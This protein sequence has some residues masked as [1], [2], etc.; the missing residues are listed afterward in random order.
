MSVGT[1]LIN[2]S[3]LDG[4]KLGHDV[5]DMRTLS[6]RVQ[7]I[8]MILGVSQDA[9]GAPRKPVLV[10][11]LDLQTRVEALSIA[12]G[13]PKGPESESIAW[14]ML[15]PVAVDM[16]IARLFGSV[17]VLDERFRSIEKLTHGMMDVVEQHRKHLGEMGSKVDELCHHRRDKKA[18]R[19]IQVARKM[20]DGTAPKQTAYRVAEDVEL[21]TDEESDDS[22]ISGRT[23]VISTSDDLDPLGVHPLTATP[24]AGS[25]DSMPS[26]PVV[27]PCLSGRRFSTMRSSPL[28]VV[29]SA[30]LANPPQQ[31]Q[32]QQQ[33]PRQLLS[34]TQPGSPRVLV[35]QTLPSTTNL[36]SASQPQVPAVA[37]AAVTAAAGVRRSLNA[38][39]PRQGEGKPIAVARAPQQRL[40]VPSGSLS[41]RHADPKSE[42]FC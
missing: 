36:R 3:S 40:V 8:E 28:L 24:V 35:R 17:E 11:L 30:A 20:I 23:T 15:D 13:Q 21:S 39:L 18:H 1:D 26:S 22:P 41:S 2:G 5:L 25:H 12:P 6:Q 38:P 4:E 10:G 29:P 37:L 16:D 32:H 7:R 33:S 27:S 19:E 34:A 31:Q 9:C 42:R 14:D